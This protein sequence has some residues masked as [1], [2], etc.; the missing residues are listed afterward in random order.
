MN[1]TVSK[2]QNA[3]YETRGFDMHRWEQLV[4]EANGLRRE[5][6]TIAAE[7][8]VDWDEMKDLSYSKRV[9][10]V[11]EKEKE[12]RG[13]HRDDDEGDEEES[14]AEEEKVKSEMV[15]GGGGSGSGGG[16]GGD[17]KKSE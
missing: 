2:R 9:K 4:N 10:K 8:D 6:K 7:Y 3:L 14:D 15:R 1:V 5:V 11:L 12:K 16:S 13:T 17:G